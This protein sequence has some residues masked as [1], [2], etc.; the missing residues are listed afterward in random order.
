MFEMKMKLKTIQIH[1]GDTNLWDR[2]YIGDL[3][4]FKYG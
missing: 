4:A 2:F 3:H 1:W